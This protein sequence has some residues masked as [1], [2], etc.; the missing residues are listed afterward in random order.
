[1]MSIMLNEL[2]RLLEVLD[3]VLLS[4]EKIRVIDKYTVQLVN[5]GYNW[6]QRQDIIVRAPL[7]YKKKKET[8]GRDRYLSGQ[9]SLQKRDNKKLTV[10]MTWFR[11]RKG[12]E[13]RELTRD[14]KEVKEYKNRDMINYKKRCQ[15]TETGKKEWEKVTKF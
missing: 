9:Q 12:K 1:M 7:G 2:K 4:E 5:F 15:N 6:K 8:E 13:E 3:H 14:N 10:K 11:R